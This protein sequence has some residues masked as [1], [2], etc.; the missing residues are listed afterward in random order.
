MKKK[1]M[2]LFILVLS[3]FTAVQFALAA[4]IPGK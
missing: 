1:I 4:I 2:V 3:L